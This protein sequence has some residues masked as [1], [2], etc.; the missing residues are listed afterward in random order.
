MDRHIILS[1]ILNGLDDK[2]FILHIIRKCVHVYQYISNT[3]KLD[4]DILE[5]VMKH[6]IDPIYFGNLFL[7][8]FNKLS[9]CDQIRLFNKNH[10]IY[11]YLSNKVR[12]KP[13]IAYI[14]I[15]HNI[16]NIGYTKLNENRE[17]ILEIM[18][19]N[20][21][22]YTL[23]GFYGM[24]RFKYKYDYD[25]IKICLKNLTIT[26]LK[27]FPKSILFKYTNDIIKAFISRDDCKKYIVYI[28][29]KTKV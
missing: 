24:S 9:K 19:L 26:I 6:N 15:K 23:L 3:L 17:F 8:E 27:A 11:M 7:I 18:K 29:N 14:A 5:S 4:I 1:D 21:E 13:D 10:D 25:I 28:L 12:D 16:Q 2:K 20:P 22:I